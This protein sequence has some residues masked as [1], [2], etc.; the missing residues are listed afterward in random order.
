MLGW[1]GYQCLCTLLNGLLTELHIDTWK[2]NT[3]S[4]RIGAATTARQANIL[5]PLIQL[6]GRWKGN[7]YLT[8]IK[9]PPMEMAKLSKHLINNYQP[10]YTTRLSSTWQ[11]VL[12]SFIAICTCCMHIKYLCVYQSLLIFHKKQ[13]HDYPYLYVQKCVATIFI[14]ARINNPTVHSY[15]HTSSPYP[16][17]VH[18]VRQPLQKF[19]KDTP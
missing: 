17:S 6:M 5:D 18:S 19:V 8:Y 9:T 14:S 11:H 16:F 4:F 1:V 10:P 12:H 2:Y 13:N 7:A 3:H 15:Y